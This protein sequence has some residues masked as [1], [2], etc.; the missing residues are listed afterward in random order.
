MG[1]FRIGFTVFPGIG[2]FLRASESQHSNNTV[3]A[4]K[5]N[6]HGRHHILM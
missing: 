5:V 3:L 1:V 6:T 2:C 4:K